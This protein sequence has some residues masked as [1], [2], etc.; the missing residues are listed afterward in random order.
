[1]DP[2]TVT[3][4]ASSVV[5]IVDGIKEAY[6]FGRTVIHAD[7]ERK[8]FDARLSY[9]ETFM[10]ALKTLIASETKA[11][12]GQNWL[13]LIGPSNVKSPVKGLELA[14]SRLNEG[15]QD[16]AKKWRQK[17]RNFEW[18]SEK[19]TLE[20]FFLEINGCC[21]SI[22]A[23]LVSANISLSRET[24]TVAQLTNTTTMETNLITKTLA[25]KFE[26]ERVMNRLVQEENRNI[27]IVEEWRRE[28]A[29]KKEIESWL[30]P[31]DFQARR[32]EKCEGAAK[33]G[34]FFL[35]SPEFTYW[36]NG[37]VHTLRCFGSTGAG[38]VCSAL[39]AC[40]I[41]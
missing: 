37:E 15:L 34:Q 11:Q 16:K 26:E 24:F 14:I 28:Q 20:Q 31:F 3:G 36:M 19:K 30:S 13:A 33:T 17:M 40:F 25:L 7:E 1:M 22:S 10:D 2:I 18:P 23:I 8:E 4:L 27:R 5:A 38:K 35:E 6:R 12:S 41:C 29:L 32:S 39:M 21:T 9:V